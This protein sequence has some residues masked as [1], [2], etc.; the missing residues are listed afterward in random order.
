[1]FAAEAN[2]TSTVTS[3]PGQATIF[4]G[5][6]SIVTFIGSQAGA[7]FVAT[8]GN[9]TLNAAGSSTAN[10]FSG[11]SNDAN[12]SMVGGSGADSLIAG[13]GSDTM[14]GG[15]GNNVFAFIA[16]GTAG[17]QDYITDFNSND[18]LL[19]HGYASSQSAASVLAG[20]S[21][22]LNGVTL[23]LSDSTKITFTNLT[24]TSALTNH[25]ISG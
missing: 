18:T 5:S 22:G 13:N 14:S 20:A 25:I 24:S 23:T 8:S 2:N 21:V 15:G 16:S 6:N 17:A 12:A 10:L 11:G 4:G 7:L 9:E 3:G 1:V 19:L